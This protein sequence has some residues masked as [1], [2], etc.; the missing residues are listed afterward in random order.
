[1]PFFLCRVCLCPSSTPLRV[2]TPCLNSLVEAPDL[3]ARCYRPTQLTC[4]SDI[5]SL[6][7]GPHFD[8]VAAAYINIGQGSM[9]MK[10]WKKHRDWRKPLPLPIEKLR[11]IFS[12]YTH[13]TGLPQT[14]SRMLALRGSFTQALAKQIADSLGLNQIVWDADPSFKRRLRQAELRGWDR[15]AS[16]LPELH[17]DWISSE[18]DI[19]R[20]V[21][22][23]DDFVTTGRTAR[24]ALEYL[25]ARCQNALLSEQRTMRL[26]LFCLGI[27][28]APRTGPTQ[29]IDDESAL[30]S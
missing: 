5:C 6:L 12:G 1:M 26:G 15:L 19:P 24:H 27:R 23:V 14:T 2:C 9:V 8:H 21:L 18:S 13:V 20:S 17:S 11:R 10:T 30:I 16:S 28:L 22:L 29:T 7:P 4:E 25:H 3:C